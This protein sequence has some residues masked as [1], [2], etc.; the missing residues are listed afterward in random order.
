MA[1]S[2]R[3][4]RF[5]A[6]FTVAILM[7]VGL[8]VEAATSVTVAWD[9]NPES[10]VTGYVLLYG[11]QPGVYTERVNVGSRTEC[12]LLAIPQ[13]TY[14]FSVQA[15]TADGSLS[16]PAAEVRWAIV[17]RL[18]PATSAPD[19]DG[20]RRSDLV[21]WH[22][23]TGQW[24]RLSSATG[25]TEAP[26]SG[27]RFGGVG[28]IPLSGDIDGD[29]IAD[30][31]VWR[32]GTGTFYWLTSS[33]GYTGGGSQQW[34]IGSLGDVPMLGDLDGDGASEL[35]V[36][37][38]S[39]GMWYWLTSSSGYNRSFPGSVAFGSGTMGDV[40]LLGDFDGDGRA[41]VSVWRPG[42][43]TFY[44]LTS[45]TSFTGVGLKQ[46]GA[47]WLGDMPMVGDFDGDGKSDLAV[48]RTYTGMWYWVLSSTGYS[49]SF[50]REVQ[51]GSGTVGDQPYL[52][53]VDGDA[54][55]DLVIRRAVTNMWHVLHSASGYTT[56]ADR[57]LAGSTG[58]VAVVK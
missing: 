19:F 22:A 47:A 29:R 45:T 26:D 50:A 27:M 15:Y 14:Y 40:P 41:D 54:K 2:S 12:T 31:I 48:W 38:P 9:R 7:L 37:R 49:S 55:A 18:L 1:P 6:A 10:N 5:A 57:F 3:V 28:D 46:W 43:G 4:A 25:L 24:S 33:S 35:I 17:N 39:S 21:L 56:G 32:A 44:W 53:D 52:A 20:D 16:A 11:T 30:L 23:S 8:R 34:G 58:S 36:W 51:F 42:D 13:G